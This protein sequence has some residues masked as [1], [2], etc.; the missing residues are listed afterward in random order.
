MEVTMK[1]LIIAITFLLSAVSFGFSQF[2]NPDS[3]LVAYY[4]FNGSTND[5][6]GNGKDLFLAGSISYVPDRNG[7]PGCAVYFDG[8]SRLYLNSFLGLTPTGN[9]SISVWILP[10]RYRPV[11]TDEQYSSIVVYDGER[12]IRLWTDSAGLTPSIP[13]NKIVAETKPGYYNWYDAY[14]L[15]ENVADWMHAV[16]VIRG[17]SIELW[18][19]GSRRNSALIV[20]SGSYYTHCLGIGGNP[21]VSGTQHYKGR[22]DDIRIY[23][24]ALSQAEIVSLYRKK[25]PSPA[26]ISAV[27]GDRKVTLTWTSVVDPF[28]QLYRIYGGESS[29]PS[30][31]IDS[32]IGGIHDTV[33]TIT[34]LKNGKRYY[35]RVTAVD[36]AGSESNYSNEMIA[37]IPITVK[38]DIRPYSPFNIINVKRNG[39]IPVA[40]FSSHD[41]NA[42]KIDPHS[43]K[44][45]PEEALIKCKMIVIDKNKDGLKD[46]IATF[47][48][49]ET[50][51]KCDQGEAV[52]T[53]KTKS[54]IGIT[55][56]DFIRV[57][58]CNDEIQEKGMADIYGPSDS[59]SEVE[60]NI[61]E[62]YILNQNYP[63]P[64]NPTTTISFGIPKLSF[65]TLIIFDILGKEVAVLASEEMEA[66]N[67]S[68]QWNALNSAGGIYF[69][70]LQSGSFT[71]TKKL[72]LIK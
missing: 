53:G 57:V 66:G 18:I 14:Y 47:I 65:V 16:S 70:R 46:I 22:M 68:R 45:G 13:G 8:V 72:L 26:I 37:D 38:I 28:F 36:A 20:G 59:E 29:S 11:E 60:M 5:S 58:G 4:P 55:G 1:N 64:F 32:A 3:G 40:I 23:N 21:S 34:G 56:R 35:F 61:P 42:T 44:F 15:T 48:T 30:V 51:I 6:S 12:S 71:A 17:D 27:A 25:I 54:G 39:L 43:L 2:I 31:K 67:Y 69:C 62:Q 50:G 41:F 63:N 33:K 19:D 24:R 52:I 10:Q 49:R 7:N 9:A